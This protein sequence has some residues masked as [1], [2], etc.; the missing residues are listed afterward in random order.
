MAGVS[1]GYAVY[2]QRITMIRKRDPGYFGV[3]CFLSP[4]MEAMLMYQLPRLPWIDQVVGPMIISAL[5]FF[6]V[7]SNFIIR[8][9]GHVAP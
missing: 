7:L 5:L 2:Q 1:Y 3:Y 9:K 4:R 6:A 8:G